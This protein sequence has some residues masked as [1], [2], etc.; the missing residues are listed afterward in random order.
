MYVGGEEPISGGKSMQLCMVKS[1]RLAIFKSWM[2]GSS[3][4]S[5]SRSCVTLATW[6]E[7]DALRSCT[8]TLQSSKQTIMGRR[9]FNSPD[10]WV[11]QFGFLSL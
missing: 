1:C 10:C 2:L 6:P 7:A 4:C 8:L 3:V 11:D 5:A 9:H